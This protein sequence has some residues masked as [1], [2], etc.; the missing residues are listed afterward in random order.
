K[1]TG[2]KFEAFLKL[3]GGK[4]GFEFAPRA[5]RK[6]AAK[7]SGAPAAPPVK[8]DFTGQT[9]LGPCPLCK[10]RVFESETDY[11]CEH[12]QRDQ[13]ACKFKSGKIILE[14]P[15]EREQMRK[16]L[17]D[18]RT[19]LLSKF[20]SRKSGKPFAAHLKLNEKGRVGFGVPG[21]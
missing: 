1:K 10:G 3:D 6:A 8:L 7:K 18:G 21:S 9:P 17:A 11:L 20:V 14:Q 5:P 15:V 4:V 16:L 19:D 13:R 12:T 2:R